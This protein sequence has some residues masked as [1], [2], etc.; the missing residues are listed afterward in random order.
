MGSLSG[1][2][3]R[4]PDQRAKDETR[5]EPGRP[6]RG[7]FAGTG[8]LRAPYAG[9][10]CW[11]V[12]DWE[13]AATRDP[14]TITDGWNALPRNVGI[15]VGRSRIVVVDLDQAREDEAPEEF[16]G[17]GGGAEVLARLAEQAGQPAPVDSHRPGSRRASDP[18]SGSPP[19][20]E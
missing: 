13:N 11:E 14:E 17:A 3:A 5:G 1:T 9:C 7:S 4:A 6:A 19:R 20:D 16:A 15:A 10:W 12:K 8:H 18:L 2:S